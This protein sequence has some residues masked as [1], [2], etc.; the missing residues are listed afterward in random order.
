MAMEFY[1]STMTFT[2]RTHRVDDESYGRIELPGN[3][4]SLMCFLLYLRSMYID[5]IPIVFR[6]SYVFRVR[7]ISHSL[8]FFIHRSMLQHCHLCVSVAIQV[9]ESQREDVASV[10]V[11]ARFLNLCACR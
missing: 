1:H 3:P 2:I 11:V 6:K 5:G 10:D 7:R 8:S 4:N 9:C